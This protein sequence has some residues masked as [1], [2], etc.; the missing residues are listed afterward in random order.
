MVHSQHS[1]GELTPGR[2][3][4]RAGCRSQLCVEVVSEGGTNIR[5]EGSGGGAEGVGTVPA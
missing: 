1:G 4:S 2:L 3:H 5:A